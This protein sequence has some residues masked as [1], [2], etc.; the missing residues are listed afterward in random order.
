MGPVQP[1]DKMALGDHKATCQYLWGGLLRRQSQ[2]LYWGASR[3]T[4][5]GGHELNQESSVFLCPVIPKRIRRNRSSSR[6]R[7]RT[8]LLLEKGHLKCSG[9]PPSSA[10]RTPSPQPQLAGASAPPQPTAESSALADVTPTCS[11]QQLTSPWANRKTQTQ[12]SGLSAPTVT[13]KWTNIVIKVVL[14][15]STNDARFPN[16]SI[17]EIKKSMTKQET[18]PMAHVAS[19]EP[20]RTPLHL[21]A[22]MHLPLRATLCWGS[23]KAYLLT[24]LTAKAPATELAQ[25]HACFPKRQ[26]DFSAPRR[27]L[28]QTRGEEEKR[29]PWFTMGKFLLWCHSWLVVTIHHPPPTPPTKSSLTSKKRARLEN[30]RNGNPGDKLPATDYEHKIEKAKA[31]PMPTVSHRSPVSMGGHAN[32]FRHIPS[33]CS[34][35]QAF[36]GRVYKMFQKKIE[37]S[38]FPD[39]LQVET[40]FK[41][42]PFTL[43]LTPLPSL[44]KV[45]RATARTAQGRAVPTCV[46]VPPCRRLQGRQSDPQTAASAMPGGLCATLQPSVPAA[47]GL[48]HPQ[49]L[50]SW[51]GAAEATT[52][53]R[54]HLAISL[55]A[56]I[57]SMGEETEEQKRE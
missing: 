19:T 3:T 18:N 30:T 16:P 7:T 26:H 13:S 27:A 54:M 46:L 8:A 37:M 55:C 6:F 53:S 23:P 50:Q 24:T 47:V 49:G 22:G 35:L 29:E 15:K 45:G 17:L 12:N 41:K 38:A 36:T 52:Q 11:R 2:A 4:S 28:Y 25:G 32:A 33:W 34:K 9:S 1:G 48:A 57:D 10:T 31:T 21:T 42:F 44:Y 5:D 51:W 39:V 14:D 20:G 56:S 40:A 43:T